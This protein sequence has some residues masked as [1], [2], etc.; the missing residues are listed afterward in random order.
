MTRLACLAAMFLPVSAWGQLYLIAGTPTPKWNASYAATL[1][2]IDEGKVKLVAGLT[3][4]D[5]GIGWIAVSTELRKAVIHGGRTVAVVDL[6]TATLSKECEL[7]GSKGSLI[8]D[9]LANPPGTGAMF[10]WYVGS[11]DFSAVGGMTLDASTPCD[12]SFPITLPSN[13]RYAAIHGTSG[14]GSL[15]SEDGFYVGVDGNGRVDS[16][17]NKSLVYHDLTEIPVDLRKIAKFSGIVLSNSQMLLLGTGDRETRLTLIFKKSDRT[18]RVVSLPTDVCNC[19]E[20]GK[21]I[22]ITEQREKKA[23]KEQQR[24]HPGMVNGD[25]VRAAGE[26]SPGSADWR[27]AETDNGP[28]QEDNFN[29]SLFI[30]PGR[31]HLYNI[32]TERV[33]TIETKQ[34]DSEILLVENNTVYYRV[35][36]RLYSAPITDKGIGT[37]KLIATDDIIRDSHWA[38]IKH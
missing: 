36:D 22:A 28:N 31:L 4:K 2:R 5:R 7:P 24:E 18:W 19:R 17:L 13:I 26:Y 23:Y 34:G 27:R 10:E 3:P 15:V 32:E 11:G 16:Y 38:F 12:A 33:F 9:W 25:A 21:F 35:T 14:I 6:D 8:Y 20:F 30:F 29:E 1:L 37:A